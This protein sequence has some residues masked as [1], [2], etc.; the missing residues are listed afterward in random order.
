MSRRLGHQDRNRDWEICRWLHGPTPGKA[1]KLTLSLSIPR[2]FRLLLSPRLLSPPLRSL[3]L[4]FSDASDSV[5]THLLDSSPQ[6]WRRLR[7]CQLCP[8][9][10]LSIFFFRRHE[11]WQ[12]C[13]LMISIFIDL[14]SSDVKWVSGETAITICYYQLIM[15]Q[16]VFGF[17]QC[18]NTIIFWRKKVV[19][20]NMEVIIYRKYKC[21]YH[22]SKIQS[23]HFT[24]IFHR[25][26]TV[27]KSKKG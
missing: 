10:L 19:Y 6:L 17:V 11:L 1:Y 24:S 16:K 5:F 20:V 27:T 23:F 8:T 9:V 22:K 25:R 21:S 14:C 7:K 4:S 13:Y 15:F 18:C 3:F 2:L 26:Q 12:F